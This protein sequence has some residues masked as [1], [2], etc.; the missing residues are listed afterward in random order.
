[1]D[2]ISGAHYSLDSLDTVQFNLRGLRKDLG[3][4][5]VFKARWKRPSP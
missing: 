1:M 5:E 4:L 3:S 2:I